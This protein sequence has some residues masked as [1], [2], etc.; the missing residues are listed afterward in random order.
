MPKFDLSVIILSFNTKNYTQK[1]I[2]SVL[3]SVKGS[4]LRVEIVLVDN[5]SEDGS[6]E[7]LKD[8]EQKLG[9]Q[10]NLILNKEN[11]GFGKANNQGVKAARASYVL[12]LNSDAFAIGNAIR[13]LYEFYRRNEDGVGF[14]GGKLLNEDGSDQPSAAPFFTLPVV[15]GV[16][17]L[18]GDYWGLTRYSPNKTRK[19][20]WITGACI[21]TSKKVYNAV[22][23]FDEGVFMYM[24]EVDLQYRADKLGYSSYFY[25]EARFT[26]VGFGSSGKS[27]SYPVQ[28]VFRGFLYLYKKH[29]PP[30]ARFILRIMLKLKAGVAILIGRIT[31]SRYLTETYEKAYQMVE[32]D[33]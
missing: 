2:E 13:K 15:F 3:A 1:S 25:P 30:L 32:M 23:G 26:H 28:Q 4:S 11:T 19:V 10:F 29:R 20:G 27:K 9:E 18:R 17:F 33:R 5:D 14:A 24:E 22:G 7:M 21:L 8:Y 16:M 6:V 31:K 12:L